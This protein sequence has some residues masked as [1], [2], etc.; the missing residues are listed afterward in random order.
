MGSRISSVCFPP[1]AFKCF[2]FHFHPLHS[3]TKR[4]CPLNQTFS[5]SFLHFLAFRHSLSCPSRVS[6]KYFFNFLIIYIL[7]NYININIYVCF[8]NL[9]LKRNILIHGIKHG[10]HPY[11]QTWF[12]SIDLLSMYELVN[13]QM[14]SY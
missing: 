3:N 12:L 2:P 6:T 14:K 10:I 13:T 8:L 7:I 1:Y 11:C 4:E 9:I 5:L